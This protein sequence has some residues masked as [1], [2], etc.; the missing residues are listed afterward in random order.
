MGLTFQCQT[1]LSFYTVHGVLAQECWSG[2]PF[3]PPVD[4]VLSE[5]FTMTLPSWVALH[6]IAHS[7]I[8]SHKP[9]CHNKSVIHEWGY[10]SVIKMKEILPFTT[11]LMNLEDSLLVFPVA[12]TVKI[13]PAMQEIQV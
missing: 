11:A 13:L 10:Y 9:L 2:L 6:S 5:L 3:P 1:F 7:F 12:Q 4:Q 8:E